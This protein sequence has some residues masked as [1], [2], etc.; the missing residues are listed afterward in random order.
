[1][2]VLNAHI[3]VFQK[4][5]IYLCNQIG[6]SIYH[7]PSTPDYLMRN[8]LLLLLILLFCCSN[9]HAKDDAIPVQGRVLDNMTG[10]GVPSAKVYLM[11]SDSVVIDS[12]IAAPAEAGEYAGFYQFTNLTKVGNYIVRASAEGYEDGYMRFVLRS[13]R[14]FSVFVKSIR[15]AKAHELAEVTVKATKVKMVFAGDTIV[16]NA[17]AF[18]LADGSILDALI[19]RLPG[20]RLTKEG[21]IFVNGK[22]IQSLL[23]NGREFFSGNPKL[24]LENLPAYTVNKIKVFNKS[25]AAS[26]VAGRNMDDKSYVMDVRLKKEYAIGYMGNIE[27]GAGSK[28]R[29]KLR[30][31]AVRFSD[32]ERVGIFA[33]NNNLNNNQRAALNGEWSPQDVGSGL[34]T[35]KSVGAQYIRFLG[36]DFSWFELNSLWNHTNTDNESLSSKQTFLY[37]GDAYQHSRYKSLESSDSWAAGSGLYIQKDKYYTIN[38]LSLSY[39]HSHDLNNSN[40]ETSDNQ[41]LLNRMLSANS[42]ESKNIDF[43]LKNSNGISLIADMIR[44]DFGITYN[45]NTQKNFSLQD[46]EYLQHGQPRDY[47]NQYT[48]CLNQNLNLTAG[49]SYNWGFRNISLQPGYNYAYSYVKTDN[50]LYRL[51][52]ISGR[53]SS[54]FDKLPSSLSILSTVLDR[55]NSYHFTQYQNSHRFNFGYRNLRSKFL[56]CEVSVELPIQI[57]HA[58]L[59]YHRMGRHDVSRHGVFFEPTIGLRSET[60]E[61]NAK[62]HSNFPDLTTMIDYRDDRNPMN[63]ILGNSQL[64]NIHYYDI[65]ANKTFNGKENNKLNINMG[66]HQTDNAVA[67]S[68]VFDKQTGVSTIQ[69]VSVNGNRRY[70]L[71][72]GYIRALDKARK[73]TLDNQASFKY[74]HS[75]DMAMVQGAAQSSWSIVNNWKIGNVL[76]L[77]YRPNDNY[78]FTFHSGGTYYL[79]KSKREGFSNI[80]A[81][82]YDIGMNMQVTLPWKLQLTTDLTMFARRGYQL[83][84]INTTD[85]IWNAQLSRSFIDKRLLVTLQGFDMLRQLSNTQYIM[86]AQG[87]TETW[88]NSIP[89]Y[90]MLSLSLRFNV[91]PKKK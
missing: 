63:V 37:G 55:D 17:D 74:N 33:N 15:L 76:K 77:N 41:S 61:I 79:I 47:R 2:Y 45:R 69:P 36:N 91:N 89:R 80:H 64:R 1:M 73:F 48:D 25:G 10:A 86:D 18:N 57:A 83:S 52:K 54:L 81:G 24:A 60:W 16:Y 28:N 49:T 30:G 44:W 7:R 39:A 21:L 66:Y 71:R 27:A 29:Y 42:L 88:N 22:Y 70:D 3:L 68:L 35:N 78:E 82:D 13:K 34:Q 19:S 32:K 23:V 4:D 40:I 38:N 58:K 62:M 65:E 50:P 20:A 67:Y 43:N 84:E 59:Y 56:K 85:W 90:V 51:D 11:T 87:R 31:L 12:L 6:Q 5:I 8:G 14:E 72:I 46:L 75:V 53:D 9:V 26:V